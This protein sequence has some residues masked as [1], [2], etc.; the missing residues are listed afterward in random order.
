M[1]VFCS[2][3]LSL[4]VCYDLSVYATSFPVQP[5]QAGKPYWRGRISTVDLLVLTRLDQLVFILKCFF[6][7]FVIKTRDLK[8]EVNCTDP[9]PSV[10]VPCVKPSCTTTTWGASGK[11]YWRERH[12]TVDLF[13]LNAFCIDNA[14]FSVLLNKLSTALSLPLR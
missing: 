11:S 14:Y 4:Y 12:S 1:L 8:E 3:R 2:T 13:V 9:S 5:Y 6:L 7:T 10:S